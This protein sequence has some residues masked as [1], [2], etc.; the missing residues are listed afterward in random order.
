MTRRT[1]LAAVAPL[2]PENWRR[3]SEELEACGP[4]D[5]AA[6]GGLAATQTG[7]AKGCRRCEYLIQYRPPVI[8]IDPPAWAHGG[9]V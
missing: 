9:C 1:Q 5:E 8:P 3:T 7:F 2:S 6:H 4:H